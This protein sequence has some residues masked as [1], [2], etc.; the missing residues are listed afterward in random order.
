MVLSKGLKSSNTALGYASWLLS[1]S[2][3]LALHGNTSYS[4]TFHA[5][6]ITYI[7]NTVKGRTTASGFKKE[8]FVF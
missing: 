6:T 7:Y 8:C 4:T 3:I 2:W 1:L 5:L